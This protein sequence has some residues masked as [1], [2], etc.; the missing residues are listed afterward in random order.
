MYYSWNWPG[1]TGKC[2]IFAPLKWLLIIFCGRFGVSLSIAKPEFSI[3]LRDY[4][5]QVLLAGLV[6]IQSLP[7]APL[8][9]RSVGKSI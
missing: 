7:T 2:Y 4:T 6:A 9:S 3:L 1:P 5:V 8:L